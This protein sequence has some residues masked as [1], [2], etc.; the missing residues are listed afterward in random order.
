[1][2]RCIFSILTA[3]FLFTAFPA[4]ALQPLSEEELYDTSGQTS[5][6]ATIKYSDDLTVDYFNQV[7]VTFEPVGEQWISFDRAYYGDTDGIGDYDSEPGFV[8]IRYPEPSKFSFEFDKY[9]YYPNGLHVVTMDLLHSGSDGRTTFGGPVMA[10]NTPYARI[11]S[12]PF[13]TTTGYQRF[14]ISL[15]GADPDNPNEPDWERVENDPSTTLLSVALNGW[16]ERVVPGIT[17][18]WVRD[19]PDNLLEKGKNKKGVKK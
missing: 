4:F 12:S 7:V 16:K 5:P 8:T 15:V 14:D 6:T 11:Y 19:T 2:K 18:T 9:Q 17:Y 13:T 3:I 10:P 1:M